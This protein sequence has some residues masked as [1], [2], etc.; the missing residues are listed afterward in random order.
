MNN[1]LKQLC[2]I[3][4]I[5]MIS[6]ENDPNSETTLP[7]EVI[8]QSLIGGDW[9]VTKMVDSGKDET[10]HFSGF[11][12]TFGQNGTLTASNTQKT[13]T[14]TWSISGSRSNDDNPKD[15]DFNIAFNTTDKFDDLNDDW[16]II[17][18]ESTLIELC[19]VSGGNGGKDY[20]VFEKK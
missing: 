5:G 13:Y 7:F 15:L 1:L 17:H 11:D 10:S 18:Y 3:L 12:F 8:S 2:F 4:I 20:L 14:G 16:D 6:C 9:I 19:D